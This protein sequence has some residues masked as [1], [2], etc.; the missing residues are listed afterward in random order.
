MQVWEWS[1]ASFFFPSLRAQKKE[2]N[3]NTGNPEAA[4]GPVGLQS[5]GSVPIGFEFEPFQTQLA[6]LLGSCF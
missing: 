2:W 1:R 5:W 6:C 3:C 4:V